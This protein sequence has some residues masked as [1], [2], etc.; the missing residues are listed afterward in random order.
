MSNNSDIKENDIVRFDEELM[1][2]LLMD[3]TR[4]NEKGVHNIIWATDNYVQRGEGYAEWS[5]ISLDA[6][7]GRNGLVLRP[8]VNKSKVEQ[9]HRTKDKAEVFTPAWMC[10]H[11]NN[12]IDRVWFERD[13]SPFNEETDNGWVTKLD[14][15]PFPTADGK[16]W[17][18]YVKD[19]R[20]EITCGEAPYLVSRYDAISGVDI[21]VPERIGL[22]DRKLRV[23]SENVKD[24]AE[25]YKWAAKA[26]QSIY[27]YEWQG[28]NL[29]IARESLL[30]DFLDH[31]E[32]QFKHLPSKEQAREIASIIS[33]NLWQMD[34]MKA[35]IPGSCY[36]LQTKS[37]DIFGEPI[38][39][40]CRGCELPDE[41]DSIKNHIGIYC[42]I[43]DWEKGRPFRFVELLK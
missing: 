21:P 32:Y 11:Q 12:M 30:Y 3:R 17:M 31:Y 16:T 42:I 43:M 25:W 33:W 8:R 15:I 28:D 23:I 13:S 38:E 5:E 1:P 26:Y 4:S 7:T 14:I 39:P 40:Y 36:N 6:V 20:I 9:E 19:N 27:G 10:N 35:V 22:L 24:E 29:I 18:D 41:P 2:L 37:Y 34:G